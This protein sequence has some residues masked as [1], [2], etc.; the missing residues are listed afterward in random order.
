MANTMG[1]SSNMIDDELEYKAK[2]YKYAMRYY[3]SPTFGI[4]HEWFAWYPVKVVKFRQ[5]QS[6]DDV[7]IRTFSWVWLQK[8]ARRKVIDHLNGP[9]RESIFP[10]TRKHYEYTTLMDLLSGH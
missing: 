6:L 3:N 10:S 7:Y 4:W 9:G 2:K 1:L 5:L 8:V